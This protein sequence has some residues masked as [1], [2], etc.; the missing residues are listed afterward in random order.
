M[1]SAG[2]GLSENGIAVLGDSERAV[3]LRA[4]RWSWGWGSLAGGGADV[5]SRWES[6]IITC[7]SRPREIELILLDARWVKDS[8]L[9]GASKASGGNL[10]E[11]GSLRIRIWAVL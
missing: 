11:S 2:E 1:L 3:L 10:P 9:E 5:A 8:G 7:G 4:M 6:R